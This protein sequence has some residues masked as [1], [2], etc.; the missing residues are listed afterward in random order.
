MSAAVVSDSEAPLPPSSQQIIDAIQKVRRQ[1]QR[2]TAERIRHMLER[3]G[4][5]VTSSELDILLELAVSNGT[6]ERIYNASGIVSYKELALATNPVSS[7]T[8]TSSISPGKA[9]PDKPESKLKAKKAELLVKESQ[10]IDKKLSC[11]S[12]SSKI[13]SVCHETALPDSKPSVVVD[14]HTDLS[15]VVLQVI[16]RLGCASIKTLEKQICTQYRLDIYPGVDIRRLIRTACKS[17]VHQRQLRQ[18]GNNFVLMGD[19]DDAA[20]MTLTVDEPASSTVDNFIET[21]VVMM[22]RFVITASSPGLTPNCMLLQ[23]LY[24]C[25]I[26]S[27]HL[28]NVTQ[29]YTYVHIIGNWCDNVIIRSQVRP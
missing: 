23:P 1:K 13:S 14:K 16:L 11:I 22:M 8:V 27:C 21:Q 17:L 18:E 15:D 9:A 24:D 5:S 28:N 3:Y 12:S 19:D 26:Q 7:S 29:C 25:P 2:P 20:D 6:V 4:S 10:K